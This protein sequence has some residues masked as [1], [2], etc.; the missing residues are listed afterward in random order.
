MKVLTDGQKQAVS[1]IKNT[2]LGTRPPRVKKNGER[3]VTVPQK[4]V[5]LMAGTGGGKT[6]TAITAVTETLAK[7]GGRC[8][9]AVVPAC[10]GVVLQQWVDECKSL[11][12]DVFLYHGPN[13]R[14]R[15]KVFKE[16]TP[17]SIHLIVTSI[18]TIHADGMAT[19][20]N[21]TEDKIIAESKPQKKQKF[22]TASKQRAIVDA[23]TALGKCEFLIVDEFQD[24]RNGSPV[25][26]EKRAVDHT[27]SFYSTLE[28]LASFSEPYI[29][30][31]SAT[32]VVNSSGDIFSFIRLGEK[33]HSVESKL[34]LLEKTRQSCD[35]EVKRMF[36]R[37]S[38]RVRSELVVSITPPVV[39]ATTYS[40]I[41]HAYTEEEA[42]VLRTVNTKLFVA[43]ERFAAAIKARSSMPESVR[44]RNQEVLCKNRWFSAVSHAKRSTISPLCFAIERERTDGWTD[45]Q[46]DDD[47]AP[48]MVTNDLGERVPLGR[49]LPFDT[50]AAHAAV[51][52]EQNSK[53]GALIAEL[54]RITDKRSMVISEFSDVIDLFHLYLKEKLP[55]REVFVFHGKVHSRQRQM[56]EFKTSTH[57]AILLATRGACGTAIN[58]ECTT[59]DSSGRRQAVVQYQLDLP[60]SQAMQSQAEGRIKRPIAQG[61]PN[62]ADRVES[63]HVRKVLADANFRTCEDW[64]QETIETKSTRCSD[65][66]LDKTEDALEGGECHVDSTADAVGAVEAVDGPI[67]LLLSLFAGFAPPRGR[68]RQLEE[69][70]A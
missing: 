52:I 9:I 34:A 70:N 27:K 69:V 22:D 26:D 7:T 13:R 38:M 60:P 12:V 36:K 41:R 30:G 54:G 62:D 47:G 43:T 25:N 8:A 2:F 15:L 51:P 66:L 17:D 20:R 16:S 48:V 45:P 39:P 24:F 28:A 44:L 49:L 4:K 10:G 21:E 29:L 6:V 1:Q 18:A 35:D 67:K 37:A 3:I 58:I 57:D 14:E 55:N 40:S 46:L 53:F 5:I 68:K 23:C 19:L 33:T 31:L 32:P 64:M 65:M 42:A 11:N 56:A 61:F 59:K 63:W 50:K